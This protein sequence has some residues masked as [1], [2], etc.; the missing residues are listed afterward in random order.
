MI[1]VIL[2]ALNEEKTIAYVVR[3]ALNS[4]NVSQVI[5]VDD[6]SNDNTIN[7]AKKAG[8][9]VI[10]STKLGKGESMR[11][12]MHCAKNEILVFLDTDITTYPDNIV[13]LLA[14]PI[15][16]EQADFVKSY[17]NRQAGRVT[18]LVAKPLLNILYPGFPY[19]RQPLSGMIAARKTFL[20]KIKFEEGYGVDIGILIDMY[21]LNAKIAEVNI[22]DIENRMHPLKQL[23]KMS[24]SVALTIL[25]KSRKIAKQTLETFEDIH[26]IRDQ[27][28][29]AIKESLTQLQKIAI[30]DMDNT[31]LR[32]S[33]IQAA[34]NKFNF[35]NKLTEIVATVSN[36][37]VRTKQ[38]ARLLKGKSLSEILK[39]ADAILPASNIPLIV[40][41]LKSRGFIVGIISD[42]YDCV[43]N[44]LKNKYGFDF[45]LANELEFSKSVATGEVKVPF[46]FL[47]NEKSCC[48]HDYCKSNAMNDIC[49]RYNVDIKNTIVIGD[50]E[51]DV[52]MIKNAGIGISFCSTNYS[53]D[54]VADHIIKKPDFAQV[55]KL[56]DQ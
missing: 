40:R 46:F 29:Y 16:N 6:K 45:T 41:E 31:L 4:K 15:I 26:I 35:V 42:S 3:Q 17:F 50:G 36:P 33:F 34:A 23:G 11:D 48:T 18:E 28:D 14:A 24:K 49:D 21:Q 37:F 30:F 52:C 12:G 9:S 1:T 20:E 39:V 54:L 7:E 8:A 55:L 43:T 25:K 38:I 19:F 47:P 2:P 32:A 44:H 53:V 13:D 5:V 10:T 27:M 56:I 51:N 22:G